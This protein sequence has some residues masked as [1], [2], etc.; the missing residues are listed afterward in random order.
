MLLSGSIPAARS[1]A[2]LRIRTIETNSIAS[3]KSCP[4]P[5]GRTSD[6]V[7]QPLEGVARKRTDGQRMDPHQVGQRRGFRGALRLM[8]RL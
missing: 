6:D 8:A 5:R 4:R 3:S 7:V 1:L 2:W